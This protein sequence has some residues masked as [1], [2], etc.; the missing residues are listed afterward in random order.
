MTVRNLDAVLRPRSIALIGASNRP[1][2]I[3]AV[4]ADN[5]RLA[6][7]DGPI[8]P[9][10]PK[11]AAVAGVLAY[12]D[13]R[14]LPVTPDLAV[15]CT[16][17]ATVP[18]LIGEL[19]ARG[20]RAAIV[21][22]AGFGEAG[23][24][25]GRN[26][27]QAMLEAARPHL[28]RVVGP[29]CLGVLSTPSRLNASFA[30]IMARPG[31]VAFV[32]QSGAM[33]T[34]VLDWATGR[35]IGFSHLVSL[36][37]MSDV[38]FGDM[39]DYLAGDAE[40]SAILLYIEAVTHARKFMS[41]ARAAARLKPVIA[42][43]AGRDA[44]GARAAAS[45]TGALAGMD[46]V[47][48]AAFQRAGV[49]R[50]E[51]L[52]ELFD[53]VE[54]LAN[55]PQVR[56]DRLAILTN[57]GGAGVLA[58]DALT[59]HGGT[60]AALSADTAARLD[61]VLPPTWS[62]NNPVD[63]IGDADGKRYAAALSA[64]GASADQ[65]AIVV[66]NCPVAVASGSEAA[67]AVVDEA[68]RSALPILTNWLG[69]ASA[70]PARALFAKAGIPTF[71]TPE[72]AVRGFMHM[73]R[74]RRGLDNLMEV[75]PAIANDFAPERDKAEAIVAAAL[76]A[77]AVWLDPIAVPDLLACYGI[78]AIRTARARD[79][80][81]AVERAGALGWPVALKILS[82]DITHKSDIGGVVLDIAGPEAL[83]AAAAAMIER[84]RKAAPGA[85]L[86]GFIVQQMVRRPGAFELILGMASDATFGPFLLF[87][88]GGTAVEVINDRALA[89]PP[90]N[91]K[92]ARETM[93]RTRVFRL[94]KGYR[95]RPAAA[96]DD[97]AVMLVRLS[98]LVCDLPAVAEFDINPLLADDRGVI[99][100]DARV[101]LARPSG[102][103]KARLAI[104][105]FP[106]ELTASETVG[107]AT[108][109]RRA[110]RPE[111][112]PAFERFFARL[113][114]IDVRMRF[115]TLLKSLSP[116][117]L[118]RLTQIDYDRDMALVLFDAAGEVASVGR[119]SADPDNT[120]AEFA[121]LVRS[122]LKGR[123]IGRLLMERLGSYARKRGIGE[124]FGDILADNAVMIAL[125][126]ELGCRMSLP[127]PS[128]LV[129][130]TLDLAAAK[131]RD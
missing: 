14:S 53:A 44:A 79:A 39:L 103:A 97:I 15:I 8:L 1:H 122:D 106:D 107:G 80:D 55:R 81:A 131:A 21:I 98:Q 52:D 70:E 7:F 28:L 88:Q 29:N 71:D 83:R 74:Y 99:A 101:K 121:I 30:P 64:L 76:D 75:P 38:D 67:Q 13:V 56:G 11:H 40:T 100:L 78:P 92:L 62:H 5:L 93:A 59:R 113:D 2:S 10:N 89:L 47:Y 72:K 130:A 46:A 119:F 65:D 66:L 104:S 17:P 26:L 102:D 24:A 25:A 94:L 49:L 51:T 6:G 73:V 123:G 111:D 95:D 42:I 110:V 41:A 77:G 57:G 27:E 85:R 105:P 3:G 124:L 33:V 54:T 126:R 96:L 20:T 58:T 60:L 112:A 68:Q 91:L 63:I 128:G 35:G 86:D 22:T 32:A 37:D 125:C 127:T 117:M 108:Y 120:K 90:L 69:G 50:V 118:A 34:A 43:K 19:G 129:R 36:G 87:G 114:P 84:A 23:N 45:H 115:F 9:V 18:E 116:D 12:P 4:T 82:P 48:D 61:R 16:P 31:R 109:L